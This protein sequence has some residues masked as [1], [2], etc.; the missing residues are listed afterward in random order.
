[1]NTAERGFLLLC[2]DLADGRTPLSLHQLHLLRQRLSGA[3]QEGDASAPLIAPFFQSLGYSEKYAAR[4]AALYDREDTLQQYLEL[5]AKK[6]CFP[7]TCVSDGFPQYLREKLGKRCPAVLFYR[8]NPAL[9]HG[10]KIAVVGSRKLKAYGSAFAAKVGELAAAEGLVLVSGNA[11]GADKT[12]Q[13]ACLQNGGSVIAVV[14][15]PLCEQ[16]PSSDRIV[17]LAES[18]WHQPFSAER[19]LGRN[20]LIHALGARSFVAQCAVGSGTWQGT[21]DALKHAIAP[22]F[23]CND[24]TEGAK[25]LEH[26]GAVS[27]T[28]E[29][30]NDLSALCPAQISL[31][32][33]ISDKKD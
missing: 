16:E 2:G 24:G 3:A 6:G 5:G 23:V 26:L 20:R 12:A 21:A 4:L 17:Y 7:L 9:L 11:R 33:R 1:M 28:L 31:F 8:G 10:R 14:S 30:L 32:D 25:G 13:E 19:A 29:A 15:E 22:V 18:G 27:V